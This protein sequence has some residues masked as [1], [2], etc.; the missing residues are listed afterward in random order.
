MQPRL[1]VQGSEGFLAASGIRNGDFSN[2]IRS[3]I[4]VEAVSNFPIPPTP[5]STS[6]M[7]PSVQCR[8]EKDPQYRPHRSQKTRKRS[9][10]A[11]PKR[12]NDTCG[13]LEP[14]FQCNTCGKIFKQPQGR[15]LH[16]REKHNPSLCIYCDFKWSRPYLYR[17]HIKKC[18][19]DV[20]PDAVLGKPKGSRRRATCFARHAPRQQ[21]WSLTKHDGRVH[22]EI[23]PSPP[24]VV[25][26]PTVNPRSSMSSMTHIPQHEP[27]Q[28]TMSKGNPEGATNLNHFMLFILIGPFS[29]L[30]EHAQVTETNL[31]RLRSAPRAGYV[32]RPS[33]LVR[34]LNPAF[35][36]PVDE[37]TLRSRPPMDRLVVGRSGIPN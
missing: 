7:P 10:A 37:I 28:P 16:D 23:G 21:V 33:Y 18:H 14:P 6:Y 20:N 1:T 30:E 27:T 29:S 2:N 9:V 3:Y 22:S 35:T 17:E 12:P 15:N 5:P 8:E 13:A 11:S 34:A 26:V 32:G 31:L 24:A 36:P 19:P 4:P 25:K